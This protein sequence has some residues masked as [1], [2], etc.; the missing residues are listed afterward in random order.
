MGAPGR[1]VTCVVC[2]MELPEDARL[3]SLLCS[4]E[5]LRLYQRASRYGVPV[6]DLLRKMM[7]TPGCEICGDTT[8]ELVVDHCHTTGEMRGFLCGTC[9][10]GIGMFR[11]D[12]ERLTYAIKY[13]EGWRDGM[14]REHQEGA[15]S[16]QLAG[17]P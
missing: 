12:P 6:A 3:D 10:V 11:D 9:N 5:C 4:N 13:L 17:T 8:K 16:A 15:A 1:H 7:E 14:G 2:S